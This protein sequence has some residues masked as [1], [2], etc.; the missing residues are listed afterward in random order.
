MLCSTG[1]TAEEGVVV[2]LARLRTGG[3]AR[4]GDMRRRAGCTAD[5][6]EDMRENGGGD[7]GVTSSIGVG[8]I[9]ER[10]AERLVG[11]DC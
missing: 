9:R 3:E 2:A 4:R 1:G 7:Q 5:T 6:R 8:S 11:I 10:F